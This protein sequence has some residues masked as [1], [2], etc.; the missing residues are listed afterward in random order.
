MDYDE[1]QKN[2]KRATELY[3]EARERNESYKQRDTRDFNERRTDTL[4]ERRLEFEQARIQYIIDKERYT[5]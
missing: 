3:E 2:L 4:E 5:P 1:L